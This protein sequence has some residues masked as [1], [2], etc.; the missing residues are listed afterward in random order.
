MDSEDRALALA[1]L[2]EAAWLGQG[3]ED[4]VPPI[5]A[6]ARILRLS[7]GQW[8]QAE[9]D[10]EAGVLVVL[11]GSVQMLCKAPGDREVLIGQ[12]GPGV[13]IGQTTRFGGGPRLVTVICQEDCRLL[14]VSDRA[15]GRIALTTPRIWEAVAAL[16]YLQLRNLL[17]LLAAAAALT[18][19]QR[20]AARIELLARGA[21]APQTLRLTQHALGEMAGLSRKAA[22]THLAE[23]ER[24]GL[25]RRAYG[26]LTVLNAR[27][28]RRIAET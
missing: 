13:A 25:I 23:F 17:Q 14:Q 10:D 19:R 7:A 18:P 20:L 9:G 3:R 27:G 5:L 15:L 8:A 1:A 12:A 16:L 28:L 4:L 21:P 11:S 6:H 24:R 2:H 22:N 26:G